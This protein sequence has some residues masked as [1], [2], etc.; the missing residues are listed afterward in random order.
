MTKIPANPTWPVIIHYAN[1]PELDLIYSQDEWNSRE[2]LEQF[3][4]QTD[5]KIIDNNGWVFEFAINSP[6]SSR[7]VCSGKR[8]QLDELLGL[9]KAHMSE[10]GACCVAKLYAPDY[11]GAFKIIID[12][13]KSEA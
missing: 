5:D 4:F 11:A 6:G 7:A 2:H 12:A 10:A 3:D 1:D 13:K 8:I 9:I